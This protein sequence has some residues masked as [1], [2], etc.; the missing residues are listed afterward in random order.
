VRGTRQRRPTVTDVARMAKVGASTVSR[1]LRGISI[2]SDAALR[3]SAAIKQLGYTPDEAARA[4]RGGSTRTIGLVVPQVDN[5][6]FSRAIQAIE[7]EAHR[8]GFA[9]ILLLHEEDKDRQLQQLGTLRR[10]RADGV[11]LA[12]ATGSTPDE[13]ASVLGETP[14]VA[15][16]RAL[17][18]DFDSVMLRNREAA[19]VATDH[20]LRHGHTGVACVT[21]KTDLVTF[22]ER[23]LGYTDAMHSAGHKPQVMEALDYSDLRLMLASALSHRQHPDALLSLSN[24]ATG[25][26]LFAFND[27]GLAAKD[28]LPLIGFDDFD[29]APLM[30]PALTV[31]R[32]PVD[33]MVRYALDLLFR[34]IDGREKVTSPGDAPQ[35]AQIITLAGELVCR[36]S[37]GCD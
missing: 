7:S 29:F 1:Y 8:R 22:R 5:T 12:S 21:A 27:M 37:C 30:N 20:L 3:V 34:K 15:F 13:I 35:G 32:Q 33:L 19:R 9:I 26:I 25:S 28:R 10:Y 16:D 11:I 24:M 4:L 18:M 36:R 2:R 31:I 17:S 6:F 14:A 23:I